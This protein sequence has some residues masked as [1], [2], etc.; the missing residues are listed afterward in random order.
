M[1]QMSVY[2]G[3]LAVVVISGVSYKFNDWGF[4]NNTDEINVDHFGITADSDGPQRHQKEPG[5][6]GTTV[7]LK[8]R[9]DTAVSYSTVF[10]PGRT[11]SGV[12][13]GL[14]SGVGY[15]VAGF[16][17]DVDVDNSVAEAANVS[18]T[19]HVNAVTVK[20]GTQYP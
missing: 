6:T 18:I 1:S 13:V 10:Y 7:T 4:R 12:F 9:A 16:V 11:L 15:E 20:S 3:K 19:L 14:S 8:G 2:P 5:L 17:K